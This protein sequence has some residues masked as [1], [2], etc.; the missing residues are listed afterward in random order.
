[1]LKPSEN[2]FLFIL[3]ITIPLLADLKPLRQILSYIYKKKENIVLKFT[4]KTLRK[5]PLYKEE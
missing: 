2:L 1:M 4:K 3:Y 5:K